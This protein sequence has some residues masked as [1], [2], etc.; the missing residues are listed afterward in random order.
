[1]KVEAHRTIGE[2]S[3]DARILYNYITMRFFKD[4]VNEISYEDLSKAIGRDVQHEARGLLTTARKNVECERHIYVETIRDVGI[5]RT[6]QIGGML[7]STTKH[8]RKMSRRS[9]RRAS[10]VLTHNEFEKAEMI[11]I[12]AELSRLGLMEKLSSN[13][14]TRRLEGAINAMQP[15]ELPTTETLRLFSNEKHK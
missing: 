4:D 10:N 14:A 12:F 9:T 2:M 11:S 5:K 1:M 15:A 8:I 7:A 13:E 6:L 3:T